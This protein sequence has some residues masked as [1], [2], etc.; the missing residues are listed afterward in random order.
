MPSNLDRMREAGFRPAGVEGISEDLVVRQTLDLYRSASERAG[1]PYLL[2][3]A[4]P[5]PS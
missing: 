3:A 4:E 1:R 2:F 5:P